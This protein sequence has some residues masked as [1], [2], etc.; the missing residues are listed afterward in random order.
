MS[1]ILTSIEGRRL[2]IDSSGNLLFDG[3]PI[4]GPDAIAGG[5]FSNVITL[6]DADF[7]AG[8]GTYFLT[9]E[10]SGSLIIVN[11]GG[12]QAKQLELPQDAEAGWHIRAVPIVYVPPYGETTQTWYKTLDIHTNEPGY[13]VDL[14]FRG[15][16][17]VNTHCDVHCISNV[18]GNTPVYVHAGPHLWGNF[19]AIAG[20]TTYSISISNG[21]AAGKVGTRYTFDQYNSMSISDWGGYKPHSITWAWF[22]NN[23]Y[24]DQMIP[25]SENDASYTLRSFDIGY[26]IYAGV[27]GENRYGSVTVLSANGTGTVS[28]L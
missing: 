7:V 28:A 20:G 27:I 15:I 8:D 25:Q 23:G 9:K 19:P 3:S 16:S 22:R 17:K 24:Y 4:A 12:A 14:A 21:G 11:S 13:Q 1:A 6:E 2:G 26:D 5:G 10:Q 18:D